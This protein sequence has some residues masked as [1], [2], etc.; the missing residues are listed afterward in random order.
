MI[1]LVEKHTAFADLLLEPTAKIVAGYVGN[2]AVPLADLP[3][4]IDEVYAA[5]VGVG[6]ATEEIAA[7][8][9]TPV[10]A[11]NPKKSITPDY[12]VCLED[13]KKFKSLKR[14]LKTS[15]DLTPEQYRE[16][17]SLDPSYPMVAPHYAATRSELAKKMGLGRKW[18]AAR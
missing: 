4:L 15:Y 11:V 16:K 18:K 6:G 8:G 1:D 12:I 5:L 14:H 17:W 2:N 9:P 3:V 10:P 13:G 7:A